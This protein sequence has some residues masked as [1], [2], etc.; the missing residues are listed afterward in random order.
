MKIEFEYFRV[1]A[2]FKVDIDQVWVLPT[3][4]AAGYVV[5][6][7]ND[8]SLLVHLLEILGAISWDDVIFCITGYLL[9]LRLNH[10]ELIIQQWFLE[11]EE[12][13]IL[14]LTRPMNNKWK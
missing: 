3:V 10:S 12:Q 9:G 2:L 6:V 5:M 11:E 1:N 13:S 14:P 7:I 8:V 4:T